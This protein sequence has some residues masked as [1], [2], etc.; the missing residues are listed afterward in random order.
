MFQ[1]PVHNEHKSRS[2]QNVGLINY[3]A[4]KKRIHNATF[5]QLYLQINIHLMSNVKVKKVGSHLKNM[6][7]GT[8]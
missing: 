8:K 2:L 1:M 6:N 5:P 3:N 7:Y 4:N